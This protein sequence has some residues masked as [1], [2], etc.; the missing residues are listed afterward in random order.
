MHTNLLNIETPA[1]AIADAAKS[2]YDLI[3]HGIKHPAAVYWNLFPEAL[4]EEIIFR[5]EGHITHDGPIA[6]TS[7]IQTDFSPN[8]TFIVRGAESENKI[9]WGEH[10]RPLSEEKFNSIYQ[11]LLGYLQGRDLFVK[12]CFAAAESDYQFPV[13]LISEKAWHNLFFHNLLTSPKDADEFRQFIPEFPIID[14]PSFTAIPEIDSTLSATFV[15]INFDQKICLIGNSGY[16]GEIMGAVMRVMNYLLPEENTL[17]LNCAAGIDAKGE[18]ALFVGLI[19]SEKCSLAGNAD[20]G[21]IGGDHIGWSEEGVFA[22][23][24]GCYTNLLSPGP[25]GQSE[26]IVG[27]RRFGT[28]LENVVFDAATRLTDKGTRGVTEKVRANYP[29][30]FMAQAS[31]EYRGKHP[32]HVFI[33]TCDDSGVL[34]P[35]AR[36]TPDQAAYY[37]LLGYTSRPS[38]D[39]CDPEHRPETVFSTCFG[40]PFMSRSP[41]KYATMLRNKIARHGTLCWLLNTGWTGGD[42][43]A[44][45]RISREHTNQL[46]ASALKGTLLGM[47]FVPDEQF[48]FEIPTSCNGV[49]KE[50]LTAAQTWADPKAYKERQRQLA[51][52][53]MDKFRKFA[54]DMPEEII[55]AGPKHS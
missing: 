7:D 13:R 32:S 27:I 39:G 17:P 31:S 33:I 35:I 41:L 48:G 54:D 10:N 8:D 28:L 22:I 30:S 26:E 4:Y 14:V 47:E 36:L 15:L 12:D 55:S 5:G 23:E 50:L 43:K 9:W 11:R 24:N 16:A 44:G 20:R 53:F 45:S 49:P 29:L 38:I 51:L 21:I 46:I 25:D 3:N 19:D 34:P 18:S 37:F 40:A 2:D 42:Y 52:L 1:R 6:V